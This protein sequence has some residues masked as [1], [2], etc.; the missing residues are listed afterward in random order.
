MPYQVYEQDGKWCV[1][2]KNPDD[3]MGDLI[4]GGCHASKSDAAA[5]ARAIYASEAK[6]MTDATLD[7]LKEIAGDS[8]GDKPE[9]ASAVLDEWK[10]RIALIPEEDEEEDELDEE[11]KPKKKKKEEAIEEPPETQI[12]TEEAVEQRVV[13][14]VN[15]LEDLLG[16]VK[17]IGNLVKMLFKKPKDETGISIWKEGNQYWWMARYSN[18]FRDS[19]NPP[20]IISSES[21]KRFEKMVKEGLAPLPELWAWHNKN[22]KVG[23]AHGVAY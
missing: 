3:S 4:P 22:W 13:A 20:E 17:E 1:H 14:G 7:L 19:D 10:A 8:E 2:K 18:K 9:R 12:P 23:K 5:Q 11:G 15:I 16:R 21:H 6:D